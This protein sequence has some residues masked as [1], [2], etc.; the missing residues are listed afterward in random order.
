[1]RVRYLSIIVLLLCGTVFAEEYHPYDQNGNF[2]TI[3][4]ATKKEKTS[5]KSAETKKPKKIDT[6][7]TKDMS[8]DVHMLTEFYLDSLTSSSGKVQSDDDAM[9]G[10]LYLQPVLKFNLNKNFFVET[11]WKLRPE[12]KRVYTNYIYAGNPDYVVGNS[13]NDDFYGKSNHVKRQFLSTDYGLGVET[14]FV[15]FKSSKF[16]AGIGKINPTFG[17]AYNTSRFTGIYGTRMPKEYELTE[18]NG[19]YMG[20]PLPTGSIMVNVFRDDTTDLSGTIITKTGRDRSFG[21]AGNTDDFSSYSV[22]F[23]ANFDRLSLNIGFRNLNVKLTEEKPEQGYVIG[24]EYLFDLSYSTKFLPFYELAYF[25]NFDGMPSRKVIYNT[26]MLPFMYGNWHFIASS[27]TKMDDEPSHASRTSY[28]HQL[29]LG[30]RFGIGLMLDVAK[31]WEK[32]V[33]K[34]D[35]FSAGKWGN[36]A[37][38][39]GVMVSYLFDF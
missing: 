26:I 14:L 33:K 5:A 31:S 6:S 10:Y 21:G 27:T 11:G 20:I 38:Y 32:T 18:K 8:L 1:M 28:L 34:A 35:N 24:L 13:L 9:N 2:Y 37:H 17:M 4:G 25:N 15:G 19:A 29:S 30:Y 16:M 12:N 39:W 22:T 36:N 3:E 7:F 23:N